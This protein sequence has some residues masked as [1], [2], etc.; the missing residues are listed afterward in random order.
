MRIKEDP[1]AVNEVM[2]LTVFYLD[3]STS[4]LAMDPVKNVPIGLLIGKV[5]DIDECTEKAHQKAVS[6]L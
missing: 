3:S 5:D 1:I 6:T 4:L 2:H